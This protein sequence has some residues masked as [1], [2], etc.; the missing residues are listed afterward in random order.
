LEWIILTEDASRDYASFDT[1]Q[2]FCVDN[3][4]GIKYQYR[5]TFLEVSSLLKHRCPKCDFITTNWYK[6]KAHVREEHQLVF[7]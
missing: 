4:L 2:V 7:W 3:G 6:L 5:E 1:N